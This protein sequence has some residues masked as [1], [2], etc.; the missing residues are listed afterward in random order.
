MISVKKLN[1]LFISFLVGGVVGSTIALLYAP[2]KGKQLRSDINSKANDIIDHGKK[3]TYD[4]WNG[5]KEAV[6]NTFDKANDFLNTGVEKIG[7][8]TEL[9]KDAFRTGFE[10]FKDERRTGKNKSS[11]YAEEPDKIQKQSIKNESKKEL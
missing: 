4:S 6:G 7:Q 5:A 2:M 9:V 8:K 11:L 3:L 10:S 1:G